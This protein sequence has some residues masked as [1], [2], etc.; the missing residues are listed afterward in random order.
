MFFWVPT[1]K[2]SVVC[3]LTQ[4]M[5]CLSFFYT[6]P[7]NQKM[8]DNFGNVFI[9]CSNSVNESLQKKFH[10]K[11]T[12]FINVHFVRRNVY[13]RVRWSSWFLVLLNI[14]DP[15]FFWS[16]ISNYKLLN[17]TIIKIFSIPLVVNMIYDFCIKF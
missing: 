13:K 14:F 8:P 2:N 3:I 16:N 6:Q 9:T 12:S 1:F 11:S 5:I 17:L 15:T 4:L 7:K 10:I